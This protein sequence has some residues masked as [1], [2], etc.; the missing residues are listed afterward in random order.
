M[1]RR[2]LLMFLLLGCAARGYF[3]GAKSADIIAC[4]QYASQFGA[5]WV[6]A[7]FNACMEEAGYKREE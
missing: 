6:N 5:V 4:R 7:E 3:P 2:A 1:K